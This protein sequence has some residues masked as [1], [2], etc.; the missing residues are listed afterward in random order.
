MFTGRLDVAPFACVFF[1]LV[2]FLLL[3]THL[4]PLPGVPVTLP[5]SETLE[6]PLG[7][8]WLVVVV[9]DQ[10]R[11]YFEQQMTSE[12]RLQADLVAKLRQAGA[13]LPLVVQA[14]AGVPLRDLVRLYGVCRRAGIASVKLQTRPPALAPAS[15]GVVLP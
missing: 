9:D 2:I 6:I 14:D 1:L 15:P 8:D 12:V 7:P 11:F 3:L 4:A 10:G 13:A 5:E